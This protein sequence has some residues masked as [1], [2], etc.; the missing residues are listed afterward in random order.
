[1]KNLAS[2]VVVFYKKR[3]TTNRKNKTS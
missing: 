3:T 2:P 1:V